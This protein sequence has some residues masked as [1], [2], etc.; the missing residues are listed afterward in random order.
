[1]PGALYV[2]TSCDLLRGMSPSQQLTYAR[3]KKNASLGV[4][5]LD[6]RKAVQSLR[7]N[8]AAP[9]INGNGADGPERTRASNSRLSQGRGF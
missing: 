7:L 3:C 6:T 9:S 8:I 5:V 4:D 1:M 2:F